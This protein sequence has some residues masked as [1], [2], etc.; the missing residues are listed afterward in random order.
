[1]ITG[2]L[3]LAQ[4]EHQIVPS[5]DGKE[6]YLVIPIKKNNLFKSEKGNVYLDFAAFEVSE[7][8][9][10]DENTHIIVQSFDKAK[11]EAM[12]AANE[13]SPILGNMKVS[14]YAGESTPNTSTEFT[15]EDFK[16]SEGNGDLPW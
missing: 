11:R 13:Q 1:M 6:D 4:L 9:R 8:K 10:K 7:A 2:K 14:E 12:K 16:S 5:K 15:A 3:N